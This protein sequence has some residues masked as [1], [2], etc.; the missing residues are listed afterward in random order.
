MDNV[1]D[2]IAKTIDDNRLLKRGDS[3]LVALSGGP[4]SVA[5]LHLL[6]RLKSKYRIRLAAA[7]LDH[8]IRLEAAEEGAF[9][10]NLCRRMKIEFHSKKTNIPRLAEKERLT[11]E[12]AGRKA[13][14][15]YFQ[16]LCER[17]GY[18][19]IAT[20][21][22]SDDSVETILFN[23]VRGSGLR[24]LSGIPP[25]RG[26]IIRPM[27][28]I[29][30]NEI[31]KWLDDQKIAYV[32]DV[33]NL[34]LDYARNRIRRKILPE[35]EKLNPLARQNILRLARNAAEEIEFINLTVVSVYE[36]ALV[37]AGKSKI[38]LDL[39]KLK[40]YDWTVKK[41]VVS[42]AYGRLS[43]RFYRPPSK[44][45]SRA[46]DVFGGR[47]GTMAPLGRD[48]WIEKSQNRICVFR[49][50]IRRKKFKLAIPGTTRIPY[51][52]LYFD[53]KLLKRSQVKKLKTDSDV[54]LLDSAKMK[55]VSVGYWKNGDR[56]RPFGMSGKKLLSDIF[57]DRKISSF[58]RKEIPLV[59]AGGKIAWI[60]GV[61][62]SNDFKVGRGTEE[63]LKIRLCGLS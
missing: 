54:A 53:S 21:H 5:L 27:I 16:Y 12:E 60:A 35:L 31:L 29:E 15:E 7:H 11:V 28:E 44:T 42:E 25:R 37:K 62:I 20:G 51:S 38:V 46:K 22:H 8:G 24:G 26:N 50:D 63:I 19:K 2:R 9:C 3:V 49:K 33:S 23:I 41:K 18:A 59:T 30:K 56:I 61:M 48:I 4:D 55:D 52:D 43:G 45:I 47:N 10:R 58:E 6:D 13:R 57:I 39:D 40:D 36:S 32:L 1:V 17:F 14:Y 34:S